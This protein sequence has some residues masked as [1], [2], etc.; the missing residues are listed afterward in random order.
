MPRR[1]RLI[2]PSILVRRAAL[3]NGVLGRSRVWRFVAVVLFGWR[4]LSRFL[5]RQ[6][7]VLT[8]DRLAPGESITVRTIRPDRRRDRRRRS[9]AVSGSSGS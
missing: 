1:S 3:T 9:R 8:I 4:F 7:E 2:S 6:E 5:V